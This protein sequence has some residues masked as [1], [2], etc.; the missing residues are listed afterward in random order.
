MVLG[1][2]SE[3]K[4]KVHLFDFMYLEFSHAKGLE[5]RIICLLHI[6][7]F[8]LFELILSVPV[9]SFSVISVSSWVEPVLK[10]VLLRPQ[11]SASGET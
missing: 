2:S 5:V 10:S 4:Q 3:I 8:C 6:Q 9:N 7:T 11:H 1:R